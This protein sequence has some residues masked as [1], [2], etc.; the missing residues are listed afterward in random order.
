MRISTLV[1]QF[2]FLTGLSGD[3]TA[4]SGDLF[5]ECRM[6]L[7]SLCRRSAIFFC[8]DLCCLA[9]ESDTLRC[10]IITDSLPEVCGDDIGA[11]LVGGGPRS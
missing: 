6:R 3:L 8:R 4:L 9:A 10:G 11:M 5:G 2:I 1:V 7:P